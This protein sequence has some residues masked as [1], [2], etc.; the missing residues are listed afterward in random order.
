MD[1]F[2]HTVEARF[3]A[4]VPDTVAL[5]R[6]SVSHLSEF[7]SAVWDDC[8]VRGDE[9]EGPAVVPG[10]DEPMTSTRFFP[11]GRLNF[12]ENL[13]AG[14]PDAAATAIYFQREDGYRRQ[15]SWEQLRA[16]VAA[17]ASDASCTVNGRS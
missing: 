3:E 9:G 11:N 13:L 17:T 5:H 2:R 1:E 7:W 4:D 14:P 16:N 8:N 12:A 15:L 6:W 10:G